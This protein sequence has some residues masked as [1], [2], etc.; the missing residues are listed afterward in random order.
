MQLTNNPMS[1]LPT[2]QPVFRYRLSNSSTLVFHAS[3]CQQTFTTTQH[4]RYL[5]RTTSV[6]I[7]FLYSFSLLT[8]CTRGGR[9]ELRGLYTCM[10]IE[11]LLNAVY[12]FKD[13][14]VAATWNW[15]PDSISF[16]CIVVYYI[17]RT[18]SVANL[19]NCPYIIHLWFV[20]WQPNLIN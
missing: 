12:T 1:W 5:H 8:G 4:P 17:D 7:K 9:A 10:S 20:L 2:C 15:C 11:N 14:R 18:Y 16:K 19:T 13:H 3:K 6:R